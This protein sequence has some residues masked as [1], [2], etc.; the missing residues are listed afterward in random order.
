LSWCDKLASTPTIGFK[1]NYHYS[2]PDEILAVLSPVMDAA[3]RGDKPAT[4]LTQYDLSPAVTFSTHDGFRYSADGFKISVGFEHV[5]RTKAIS[6]GPPIME[7]LSKPMPFTVLLPVVGQKLK[8]ATLLFEEMKRRTIWRIGIISTTRVAEDDLPPGI[9][10]F[11]K[12]LGRP[13][14][15][16][17]ASYNYHV[18]SN[19][20]DGSGWSDRCINN[21]IKPDDDPDELMTLQFDWQRSFTSGRD[22]TAEVL[23]EMLQT[24]EKAS[25]NHFEELAEGNQFDESLIRDSVEV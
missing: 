16:G 13:W 17:I 6:G 20:D 7:M 9:Q 4:N 23:D 2:P 1:L 8:E 24:A 15:R 21:L 5:L 22:I 12:Y 3:V 25:L 18:L 14:K 19:L 10:R 11:V